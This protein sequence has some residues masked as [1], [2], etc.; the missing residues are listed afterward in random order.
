MFIQFDHEKVHVY[1]SSVKF[2]VWEQKFQEEIPM[3]HAE[4]GLIDHRA[5]TPIPLKIA[6]GNG[7]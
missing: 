1:Q 5:S 4:Y 3:R 2:I 6:E 7:Q